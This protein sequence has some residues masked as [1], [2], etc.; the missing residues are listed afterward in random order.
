MCGV[1]FL[2]DLF[3][4]ISEDRVPNA[5]C[6]CESPLA[7]AGRGL[8]GSADRHTGLAE[9]LSRILHGRGQRS[10]GNQGPDKYRCS[11]RFKLLTELL[12]VDNRDNLATGTETLL[13]FRTHKQATVVSM[14]LL[15]KLENRCVLEDY[16]LFS[17]IIANDNIV[18][19]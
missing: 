5:S 3:E 2:K 11:V 14:F 18:V 17:I 12:T 9:S 6:S 7:G 4:A 1:L 15:S 16:K 8:R 19:R 10:L 13:P